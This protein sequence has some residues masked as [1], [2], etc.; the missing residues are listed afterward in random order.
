VFD[1][2]TVID[3][4]TFEKPIQPAKGVHLVMANGV[5]VWQD[6]KATGNRPGKVLRRQEQLAA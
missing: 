2:A 1:P 3:V 5:A 6:G 4:A